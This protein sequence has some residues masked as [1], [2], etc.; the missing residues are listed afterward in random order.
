M[1]YLSKNSK[2]WTP[3]TPLTRLCIGLLITIL[4]FTIRKTIHPFVQPNVPFHLVVV[5]AIVTEFFVGIAVAFISLAIGLVLAFYYFIP[6]YGVFT[7]VTTSDLII[8]A[9]NLIVASTAIILLEYLR[10]ANYSSKL[11]AQVAT[12]QRR[13]LAEVYNQVLFNQRKSQAFI[14]DITS[15]F[16]AIGDV[17]FLMPDGQQPYPMPALHLL[18]NGSPHAAQPAAWRSLIHADDLPMMEQELLGLESLPDSTQKT[19]RF[20]LQTGDGSERWVDGLLKAVHYRQQWRMWILL[21]K[22]G[23]GAQRRAD[24]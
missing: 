11:T 18:V 20:R 3:G 5:G 15:T 16:A 12:S 13:S 23:L 14:K 24:D 9:N 8:I 21:A 7:A 1:V 2:N 10:R 6:P 4:A 22:G 17:L 19:L